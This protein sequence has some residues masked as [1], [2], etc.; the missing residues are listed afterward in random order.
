[1]PTLQCVIFDLDGLLVDSE[2]LQFR[3]YQQAFA[4]HGVVVDEARWRRWLSLDVS[5]PTWV[6]ADE[7]DLD[8]ELVRTEK[9]HIYERLV[10]EELELKPGAA[11]LVGALAADYRLCVASGSRMESI[12]VCLEKFALRGHFEAL[13][14]CS[15]FARAKPHPDVYLGALEGMSVR[16][17]DAIALEDTVT[18]LTAA[19]Q[20]GLQCVACPDT[21]NP[22][23][24]AHY[25]QA[26]LVV[27]SLETIRPAHLAALVAGAG[28]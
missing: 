5:V 4:R 16:A 9:R 8:P 12:E 26:S 18:G 22:V 2:P 14:S 21:S 28:S 1:M 13:F 11:D 15:T 25:H 23:P 7:L 17:E 19:V 27:D 24:K 6:A 10:S 3:S 20:A